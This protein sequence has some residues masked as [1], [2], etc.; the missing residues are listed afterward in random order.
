MTYS[1]SGDLQSYEYTIN[2]GQH[3]FERVEMHRDLG[4]LFDKK[5]TFT[6]HIE[7]IIASAKGAL[8][9][10]K[11]TLKNKFTIASAKLLYCA[12]VRSRLEYAS[13]VWQPYHR[14]HSDSIESIQK[15]F[16]IWALRAIFQRDANYRLPPYQ[17][18]CDFL[19]IQPLWRRRI[20]ASIFFIYDLLLGNIVSRA[21]REKID[22]TRQQYNANQR[23]LRNSDLIRISIFRSEYAHSQPF[24]VACRLFNK[25]RQQFLESATRQ[26]FRR[27]IVEIDNSVFL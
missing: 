17:F 13:I 10:I 15:S 4:V 9:F 23:N 8:G 14:I 21:L 16:I 11:R 7:A 1:R 3:T 19:N 24:Y 25:V 20:N 27:R 12:L 26:I 5:L 6:G 22:Y 2:D 18:R